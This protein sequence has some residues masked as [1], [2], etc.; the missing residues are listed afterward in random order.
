MYQSL[1]HR[2]SLLDLLFV[3]I[4]MTL[5]PPGNVLVSILKSTVV[6]THVY[7]YASRLYKTFIAVTNAIPSPPKRMRTWYPY[8]YLGAS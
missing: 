5:L 2:D 6:A 8:L 3:S 7:T 1:G 4:S